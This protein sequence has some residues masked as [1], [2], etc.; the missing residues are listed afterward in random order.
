MAI[1]SLQGLS[2]QLAAVVEAAG[3]SVVRVDARQRIAGTGIAWGADV[4]LT[5]DHVVE[6]EEEITVS[7]DGDSSSAELIGRDPSTDTAALRVKSGG[8]K[9]ASLGQAAGLKVGN[10]VVAIGRP[11]GADAIISL[12]VVSGK[13]T[14]W[15]RRHSSFREGLIQADVTLYPGFSG[16]PLVDASGRVVGMNTS[17][18]GRDMAL[19]VPVETASRVMSALLKEGRVRRGHLGVGLQLIPLSQA[20]SSKLGSSQERA[21]MVLTIEQGSAAE[22]AGLLPGDILV[23]ISDQG[24]G[25]LEDLQRFLSPDRIGNTV[26]LTVVR[27][28]EIK[29]INVV[30]GSK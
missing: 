12:G 21:L 5:A 7:A 3:R 28:G 8:L 11:W 4:V 24:L 6:R 18:L 14:G 27:G 9:Q 10:L 23:K 2:D 26:P 19:A 20:I 30:V 1:E 16:G 25:G 29:Q 15:I 22:Q 17:V 13:G